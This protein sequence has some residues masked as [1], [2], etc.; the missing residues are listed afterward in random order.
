[1]H[2][3]GMLAASISVYV[4]YDIAITLY[5]LIPALLASLILLYNNIQIKNMFGYVTTEAIGNNISM[6]MSDEYA[7][8][9]D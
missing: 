8:R 5:S 2:F 3:I 9:Q 7:Q 6:L 1:M 4:N